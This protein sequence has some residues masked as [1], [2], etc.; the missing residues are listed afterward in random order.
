MI[1]PLQQLG[2]GTA[3]SPLRL[4]LKEEFSPLFAFMPASNQ[5][6]SVRDG[7]K[8]MNSYLFPEPADAHPFSAKQMRRLFNI[9]H[10]ATAPLST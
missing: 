6:N 2:S 3:T 7:K 4:F 9:V 5:E 1:P 10:Q 8:F